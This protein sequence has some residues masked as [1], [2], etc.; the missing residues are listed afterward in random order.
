MSKRVVSGIISLGVA[1]KPVFVITKPSTLVVIV[2]RKASAIVR[3]SMPPATI[4]RRRNRTSNVR[5]IVKNIE[6]AITVDNASARSVNV[7]VSEN[8]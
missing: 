5:I 6:R 2:I 3:N 8:H 1:M 7:R 4:Y